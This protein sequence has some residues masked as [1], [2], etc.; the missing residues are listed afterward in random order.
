MKKKSSPAKYQ[1]GKSVG[2]INEPVA[3]Y[4]SIK[5]LHVAD[6]FPYRKFEKISKL[7]PF[8][9]KEWATI[10]HLSEKTLQRYAKTNKGFEGIYIDRIL[11]IKQLIDEGLE[12]FSNSDALCRWLKSD[13]NILGQKIGFDALSSTQGIQI[14]IDELGRIQQGIII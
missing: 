8:T 13:K 10:L 4:R 7:I 14:L 11:H 3:L 6:D 5:V 2:K 12:T 1:T 9:Q